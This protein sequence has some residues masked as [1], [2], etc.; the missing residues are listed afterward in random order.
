MLEGIRDVFCG[1]NRGERVWRL[2]DCGYA[3]ING[4]SR[5][6]CGVR[7]WGM[8]W[9]EKKKKVDGMVID[10]VFDNK[11]TVNCSNFLSES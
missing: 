2:L 4:L 7:K 1:I 3:V 5:R 10:A 6:G 8:L 11:R 9:P